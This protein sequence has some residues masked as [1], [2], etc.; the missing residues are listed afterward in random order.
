MHFWAIAQALVILTLANTAPL[1]AK[2][3]LGTRLARPL[4]G[5]LVLFDGRPLFGPSKTIRGI[6]ASILAATAGAPIVG[7]APHVGA[8]MAVAAMAGDLLSSFLKRRLGRPPSSQALGLDQLP[9]SLL[10]LLVAS[11]ALSLTGLDIAVAVAAFFIGELVFAR[12]F[13]S[14]GWRD[15]PY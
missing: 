8:V 13:Y 10:P 12:L 14:I 11:H 15:E 1:V 7:I 4:D 9:E 5:G 6:V 2:K 3:L